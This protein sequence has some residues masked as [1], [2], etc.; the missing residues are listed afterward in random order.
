LARL[1]FIFILVT[2]LIVGGLYAVNTPAWQAPDEP[3]HYNY[4]AQVAAYGC[5][6]IIQSGDWDAEYLELLKSSHFNT[7]QLDNLSS[8]QYEDHQPPLYYVLAVPLFV[9]TNGNLIALRLYSVSLGAVVVFCVYLIGRLLVPARVWVALGAAAFVAFLPQ[10]VSIL[11]SVNND[12][13]GWALIAVALLMTVRFLITPSA[14]QARYL[15]GLGVLVGLIFMTKTTGYFLAGIVP[16]AIYLRHR[17]SLPADPLAAVRGP[18]A[19]LRDTLAQALRTNPIITLVNLVE[20]LMIAVPYWLKRQLRYPL[21]LLRAWV[22]FL[23]PA[24]LLGGLWWGRNLRVYGG[25]DFLGLREHDRVVVGQPRTD[26]YIAQYGEAQYMNDLVR[27]TFSSF[28]GQFGWMALPLSGWLL[29]VA[30]GLTLAA[31][32]GWGVK[33]MLHHRDTEGTERSVD[34]QTWNAWI[35]L[36]LSGVLAVAAY[37]YYNSEFLQFQG[38]YLYAGLIPYALTFALGLEAWALLILKIVGAQRAASLHQAVY[39]LITVVPLMLLAP[40]C[41]YLLWRV[42]VPGLAP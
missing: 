9:L 16:L 27:T 19:M 4:I 31:V 41:V 11:A 40:F 7:Q 17:V 33:I 8:I 36:A 2:Y 23:L 10:H 1:V 42:I 13:L 22:L 24:L 21:P 37:A 18:G 38:R 26:A 25:P 5:C 6:P 28:W 32:G 12:A 39:W 3:A 15:V 34:S 35:I 14:S 20:G 29:W 30:Q